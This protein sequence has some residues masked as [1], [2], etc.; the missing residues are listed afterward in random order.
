MKQTEQQRQTF[1]QAAGL[2]IEAATGK[3]WAA[4]VQRS[5]NGFE[6]TYQ[7]VFDLQ[8]GL[9]VIVG[10][11]SEQAGG[12][13]MPVVV[14]LDASRIR[15]LEMTLPPV[16]A[17]RLPLLIRTQAEAQLPLDGDQM[18]LAWR[19]TPGVAGVDCTVAAVRRDATGAVLDRL[20]L[21]GQVVAVVPDAAGF[22]RLRQSFFSATPEVSVVLRR[23]A[24][25]FALM[26]LEGASPVRCAVIHADPSDTAERPSLVMQD[27]QMEMEAFEKKC[28]RKIPVYLWPGDEPFMQTA[29]SGLRHAGWEVGALEADRAALDRAKLGAGT[30]L[31]GPKLDAAGLAILGLSETT[32]AFD[33]LQ[34]RRM[35]QPLE[36]ARQRKKQRGWAIGITAAI[37]LLCMAVGHW[38]LSL[39]VRQLSRELAAEAEGLKAET[40]LQRQSY[41]EA[42][43]RARL[44]LLELIETIQSSRDGLVLDSIEFEMGK[45]VKLTAAAGDYAQVYGF[46]QRLQTQ[47]GVSG[48]RLIEPRMDER[49]KQ[50]RFTMQ[51]QY[52][53]FTK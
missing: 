8:D 29:A 33:F 12:A 4:V 21:N 22:A 39:Q 27:I 17:A 3:V 7:A 10:R 26:L 42:A 35:A 18:Q 40:L 15:F 9:D 20:S 11:L 53:H 34:V 23:R 5:G 50:V 37:V 36:D 13:S 19:L 30:E 52:K 46:Q 28:G 47:N 38:S 44:D 51:F 45:P 48:V 31:Y 1:Q 16:D 6:R 43:A 25:G 41:Q 14:G 49:T 2:A 24:D 32:P